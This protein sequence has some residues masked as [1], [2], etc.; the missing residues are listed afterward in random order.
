MSGRTSRRNR[1]KAKKMAR[2]FVRTLPV[3]DGDFLLIRL[4]SALASDEL[5]DRLQRRLVKT[6]R[7]NAVVVLIKDPYDLTTMDDR[8]LQATV[9]KYPERV[10][11]DILRDALKALKEREDVQETQ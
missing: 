9:T 3:E 7:K 5:L 4:D 8:D 1:I 10:G 6:G 2:E 11:E